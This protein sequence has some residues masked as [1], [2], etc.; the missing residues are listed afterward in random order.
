MTDTQVMNSIVA[1]IEDARELIHFI[2]CDPAVTTA[3]TQVEPHHM[4][5]VELAEIWREIVAM[6]DAMVPWVRN[7]LDAAALSR[8]LHRRGV[9]VRRELKAI[10]R[11]NCIMMRN[12][13]HWVS[14]LI[15]THAK[16]MAEYRE[17]VATLD[18][19]KK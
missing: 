1:C 9:D 4:P 17:A 18:R 11:T 8:R 3:R 2:T 7:E 6:E 16:E 14:E 12:K 15:R 5:T 10:F 13:W 19:L